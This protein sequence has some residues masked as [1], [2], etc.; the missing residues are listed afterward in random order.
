MTD[1]QF[2]CVEI[3]PIPRYNSGFRV[4]E[5]SCPLECCHKQDFTKKTQLRGRSVSEI[6]PCRALL[7]THLPPR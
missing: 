7:G 2:P 1:A 4:D 3:E 5:A 6:Q